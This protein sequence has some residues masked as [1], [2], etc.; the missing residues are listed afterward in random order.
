MV[1]RL[2]GHYALVGQFLVL[3]ALYLNL[4]DREGPSLI[5]WPLLIAMAAL[6]HAYI[7]AM[8][9]PLWGS[10]IIRRFYRLDT[11]TREAL[12]EAAAVVAALVASLWV[13]GFFVNSGGFAEGG[14]G[15]YRMDI[16]SP[17]N[18]MGWSY[19]LRDLPSDPGEYEG[20]NFIGTGMLLAILLLIAARLGGGRTPLVPLSI[21][22]AAPCR[23][24]RLN[25]GCPDEQAQPR[26]VA[27][28]HPA[29][30]SGPDPALG[31]QGVGQ[32]LLARHLPRVPANLSG[33]CA[34]LR[35]ASGWRCAGR[36]P[37]HPDRRYQCGLAQHPQYQDGDAF[38]ALG[39]SLSTMPSG[40][41][42]PSTT[43]TS[44]LFRKDPASIDGTRSPWP[45]RTTAWEP[46]PRPL[47]GSIP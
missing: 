34:N 13:A 44:G 10:D 20:F 3:F 17:L 19:I 11:L 46:L 33:R 43:P 5:A 16:L 29:T 28:R 27:A 26:S 25:P 9:L 38:L 35:G 45:R 6:T 32:V 41:S 7:L 24:L 47:L 42:P 37:R 31:G 4:T 2:Y 14:F 21:D 1:W 23:P 39:R 36:L 22:D 30:G 18:P 15:A 40:P 8:V 12:T